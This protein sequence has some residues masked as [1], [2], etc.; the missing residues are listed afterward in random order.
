MVETG[1]FENGDILFAGQV[2]WKSVGVK[3]LSFSYS[4]GTASWDNGILYVNGI[5]YAVIFGTELSPL[6][7]LI[8]I[9]LNPSTFIGQVYFR[10]SNYVVD[11]NKELQ[12]GFCDASG[13]LIMRY[14]IGV[15]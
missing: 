14:G 2:E 11:S 13:N 7:K 12:I 10:A 6:N 4:G 3:D 15:V 1:L 8:T 9:V 5:S